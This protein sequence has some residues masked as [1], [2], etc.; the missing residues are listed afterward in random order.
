MK[1]SSQDL[2]QRF[3][4]DSAT[5]FLCGSCLHSLSSDLPYPHT[6]AHLNESR[7]ETEADRFV[8]GF[9][10]AQVA[11]AARYNRGWMWP[12]WEIFGDDAAE[13][14]KIVNAFLEP[15]L[16]NAT[17]KAKHGPLKDEKNRSELDEDD[18]LIDN[19]V[20]YTS[21]ECFSFLRCLKSLRLVL[22]S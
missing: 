17:E 13:G 12:L 20:R 18:T 22:R 10:S 21:G 11:I 2:I 7:V 6:V 15:V 4:L 1:Y 19:L 9:A 8:D 5:E 16:R 14:M 3:T